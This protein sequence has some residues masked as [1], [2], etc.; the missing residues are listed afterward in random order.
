MFGM[1]IVIDPVYDVMPRMTV[2]PEFARVCPGLVESTN[3]WMLEFFGTHPVVQI[4][5]DPVTG[6]K[7][8]VMGP[9]S[10]EKLPK[11]SRKCMPWESY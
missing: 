5:T 9:R 3:A 11:T 8:M 4:I 10:W 2:S 6:Q 7:R 1:P